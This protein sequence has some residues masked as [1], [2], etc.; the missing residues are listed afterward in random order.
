MC[1]TGMRNQHLLPVILGQILCQ[2]IVALNHLPWQ[3]ADLDVPW[4]WS[5]LTILIS[6]SIICLCNAV[7]LLELINKI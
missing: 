3:D 4:A 5:S 2:Q 1:S 6:Y 7:T